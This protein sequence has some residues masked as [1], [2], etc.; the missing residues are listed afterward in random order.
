[1]SVIDYEI[2]FIRLSRYATRLVDTKL[3]RCLRFK[4]R[5][6]L[7]RYVST[8]EDAILILGIDWLNKHR[9]NLDCETK[10]VVLKTPINQKIVMI[11]ERRGF[12]TNVMSALIVKEFPDVFP[13]ELPKFPLDREVEFE[14]EVYSDSTMVSMTLYRMNLKE[15]KEL[16]VQLQELLDKG[17]IRPNVS[18]WGAPV[19]FVKKKD[20]TL[21][22]CINYRKMNKLTVKNKYPLPRIDDLFDQFQGPFIFSKI[23]SR[24]KCYIYIDHKSL[25]YLLTQ[26]EMN[27]RQRCWLELLKDY[28][29]EIEYHPSKANVVADAL[30]CNTISD[31][32][33]LFASL[34]FFMMTVEQGSSSEYTFDKDGIL[35]FHGRHCIPKDDELMWNILQESHSS[36]YTMHSGGEEYRLTMSAHFIPARVNY[37][38]GKLARLYFY[39]IVRL[40]CVSLFII[41]D[42]DPWFTSRFWK[43][44]HEIWDMLWGCVIDFRGSWEDFLPLV[45]FAYNNN[46][47]ASIRMP[48]YEALYGRRCDTPICWTELHDRKTLGPELVRETENTIILIRDLLREAFD[49]HKS[50]ADQRWNDIEFEVGDQVFLKVS[51]WKNVLIFRRKGSICLPSS[52][53]SMLRQYHPDPGHNIQ[54]EYIELRPNLSYDEEH[55]QILD[56]DERVLRNKC[57]P[58][59]KVQ[60]SNRAPQ[61]YLRDIG[62]DR[63]LDLALPLIVISR[64]NSRLPDQ[65][66]QTDTSPYRV[67]DFGDPT[68]SDD[69]M[70]YGPIFKTS[71]VGRRVIVSTNFDF[72]HFVFQQEGQLF[73]SWYPDTFTEIFGRQ[74]VGSLH[75]FMYRYLK[76][77]VLNLFGPESLKKM[78]PEVANTPCRNLQRWS[79]QE[80]V[81]L[82]EAT[83]SVIYVLHSWF[84]IRG[85]KNAM[86]MLKDLLNER[87]SVPRKQQTDFLDFAIEELQKEGT[88][89]TEAIALDLMFVLLFAS[90][91]TTS[92]AITLAVKFLSD[93]PSVLN[94]LTVCD[95]I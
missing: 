56:R 79:S 19:L 28:D 54:D 63:D 9:V 73:Q 53:V 37:S 50:Y 31:L 64:L 55:I 24:E 2:E 90:F 82:K 69:R 1:M 80:S 85:R 36:P 29:Y 22:L 13:E 71:L 78:L 10:R 17:F 44:L 3:D 4:N 92:L 26:K 83:A 25:K 59:V 66:T 89:L 8:M 48:P 11:G 72:N 12:L 61:K 91:K 86:K 74:N 95:I 16:K 35:C 47:H 93:N 67:Y 62:V 6:N 20:G 51:L 32:R 57:I 60:W 39:K 33:A 40:H 70:G 46:E 94:K 7:C 5:L 81:E 42:L 68:Y 76:N 52:I 27:L 43:A 34:S 38:L 41:S 77:M 23:D 14:I 58:M 30:S 49:R 88:I 65:T 18:P 15:L 21:R 75:G 84:I 45:E 87:P